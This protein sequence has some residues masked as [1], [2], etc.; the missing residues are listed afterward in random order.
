MSSRCYVVLA[1]LSVVAPLGGCASASSNGRDGSGGPS[2]VDQCEMLLDSICDR[3]E[4]CGA[5]MGITARPDFHTSCVDAQKT[6]IPCAKAVAVDPA[7]DACVGEV[8]TFS[9]GILV[10]TDSSTGSPRINLPASCDG[11]IKTM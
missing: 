4:M 5:Q 11:A 7:Y 9:C 10:T 6:Q 3:I 1:V 8:Q 2:P